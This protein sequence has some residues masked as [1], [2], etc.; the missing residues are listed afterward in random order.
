MR[1]R[2]LTIRNFRGIHKGVVD[3]AS[4]TLLVGGNNVGK[5]TI[6]EALE[7]VLGTERL[8]RRPVIDE[9][10][11]HKGN[12]LDADG[13]PIEIRIDAIL[14]DL[15][16]DFERKVFPRTRPWNES[17]GKFVDED[18]AAPEDTD[19]PGTCRC[20][21]IAFIGWYD[22]SEDDFVGQTY[23]AH[24]ERQLAEEDEEYGKPSA[25]LDV[26]SREWKRQC[27]F[28]YLRTLRTGR[29]ALSLE[30]GSL[31]DIILRLGDKG[32]ESM[33]EDTVNRL[34]D[35]EPPIGA[36]PQL[37]DIRK[38]VRDRMSR[39]VGIGPGEEAISFYA[40][41]LTR[42][43]L[44][45]VVR[46]FVKSLESDHPIP[47]HRLGTG[48]INTLV[49]ALLTHIADLKGKKSVIFAM[50]E[51]EI[52]LPPHA[53]RRV[54]R[55]ILSN[56]G[57]AILTSHSPYVIEEFG[58]DQIL[59]VKRDVNTLM[60]KAVPTVDIK[61]KALRNNRRQLAEA[62]L[63][64]AVIVAEGTSE[65][66]MLLAASTMLEAFD[67]T[68]ATP[69]LHFDLAGVS[70]FDAGSQSS[71]PKW[72]PFFSSLGRKV[73]AFHDKPKEEWT[74]DNKTNLSTYDINFE[75]SYKGLEDL[76][77]SEIPLAVLK[78]FLDQVKEFPDYPTHLGLPSPSDSSEK[79]KE[80]VRKVLGQRKGDGYSAYLIRTCRCLN[81]LPKSVVE[82]L[83]SVNK[84]LVLP[85]S[86]SDED[87]KGTL[88]T[89]EGPDETVE[90]VKESASPQ[91]S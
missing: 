18:G 80:L 9:H 44:R 2:R 47:F 63:A 59:A 78:A 35:L 83:R 8:Y 23:F 7:L 65:V 36:I 3:F 52:A 27:G 69:Y 12:Y 70:V 61:E 42:E 71:V 53:Q 29:R 89:E 22:R 57:Q 85:S 54:T 87:P 25:G 81:D 67:G 58:L 86:L 1:V 91:S 20:L 39:F 66:A 72:G 26:F 5:S 43:H 28:I 73:A 62:I 31:L 21:P 40:S 51:P 17:E 30:R 64:Q 79:T 50:E 4:H 19:M 82:F 74:E 60:A 41:E 49:F 32:K 77:T 13:K 84:L 11:F 88:E 34:R 76:L 75:T 37:K 45:E 24:P 14:I 48:A 68:G 10:D 38:Q 6:C 90:L 46:F 55:F 15:L 16:E 56:M 33:W